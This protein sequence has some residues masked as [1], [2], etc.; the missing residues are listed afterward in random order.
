MNGKG[1]T[2]RPVN[3]KQFD[4]N[5]E[6]IFMNKWKCSI[7]GQ[8]FSH[9]PDVSFISETLNTCSICSLPHAEILTEQANLM[10]DLDTDEK[11]ML[12]WWNDGQH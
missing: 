3:K 5:W 12:E 2:F 10:D 11:L 6:K 9:D 8:Q 1:D 4:K 7:C